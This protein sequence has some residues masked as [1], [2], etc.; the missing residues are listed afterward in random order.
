MWRQA[1]WELDFSGWLRLGTISK[2]VNLACGRSF[3][4]RTQASYCMKVNYVRQRK[5]TAQSFTF[6]ACY[7]QLVLSA[8][9]S[10]LMLFPLCS[11]LYLPSRH[12]SSSNVTNSFLRLHSL[13]GSDH[14]QLS[15]GAHSICSTN[16][17]MWLKCSH[18]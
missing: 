14:N 2:L 15:V 18:F 3:I 7:R 5:L 8:Y 17:N 1:N 6:F 9:W 16:D 13:C 12:Q 11:S 10:R 4:F